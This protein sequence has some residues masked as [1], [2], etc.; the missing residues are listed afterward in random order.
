MGSRL[1][2]HMAR[3]DTGRAM[4][5]E[6]VSWG[7]NPDTRG[8]GVSGVCTHSF[9]S[10]PGHQ[11]PPYFNVGRGP[12]CPPFCFRDRSIAPAGVIARRN[13]VAILDRKNIT[14]YS[15]LV[16]KAAQEGPLRQSS[17][18]DSPL[19]PLKFCSYSCSGLLR[20]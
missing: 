7:L 11:S 14:W 20:S 3:N 16:T 4:L 1:P 6:K 12:V 19:P 9:L 8:F 17:L 2:R 13:D 5:V 10:A 18:L 15:S